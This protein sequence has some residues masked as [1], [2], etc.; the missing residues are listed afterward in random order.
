MNSVHI[1]QRNTK[2]NFRFPGPWRLKWI[3]L[4]ATL[5]L[6][7]CA[8]IMVVAAAVF[9]VSAYNCVANGSQSACTAAAG[10]MIAAA[11]G[12]KGLF[13]GIVHQD[14]PAADLQ[15]FDASQ[16]SALLSPQNLTLQT[17]GGTATVSITDDSTG[18]VLGTQG[19]PFVINNDVA[20][21]S[22]PSAVTQWVR[23]FSGYAGNVSV[24]ISFDVGTSLPPSGSSGMMTE[25]IRYSGTP[26]LSAEASLSNGS[27]CGGKNSPGL[28]GP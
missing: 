21:F 16:A 26:Y 15:Y 4:S 20:T 14:P 17:T 5:L 23:S 3:A 27:A 24:N 9:T 1:N 25:T 19:F 13:G 12:W 6:S 10:D 2:R 18:T 22:D 8:F 28:C 7:G 11:G